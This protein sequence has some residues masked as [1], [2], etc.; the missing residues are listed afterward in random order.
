MVVVQYTLAAGRCKAV[1]ITC[2]TPPPCINYTAQWSLWGSHCVFAQAETPSG[3]PSPTIPAKKSSYL[4]RYAGTYLWPSD[5]I[6]TTY[7]TPFTPTAHEALCSLRLSRRS[8][9]RRWTLARTLERWCQRPGMARREVTAT[10]NYRRMYHRQRQQPCPGYRRR[11]RLRPR[12][13]TSPQ[14]P[15]QCTRQALRSP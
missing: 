8:T 7:G 6:Y 3:L 9:V 12:L 11:G 15:V 5:N 1:T 13:L 2:T 14:R 10:Q 4:M